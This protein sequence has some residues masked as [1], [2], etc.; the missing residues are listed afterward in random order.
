M[1]IA[2]IV[3]SAQPSS[4]TASKYPSMAARFRPSAIYSTRGSNAVGSLTTVTYSCRR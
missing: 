3:V 1:S 4:P 2:T